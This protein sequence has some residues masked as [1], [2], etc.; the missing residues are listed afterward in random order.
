[1]TAY[2]YFVKNATKLARIAKGDLTR[3]HA[4]PATQL[5]TETYKVR[6]VDAKKNITIV[7]LQ[8]ITQFVNPVTIL[9]ITV[10]LPGLQHA[11]RAT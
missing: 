3:I 10:L 11:P 4:L 1:M 5:T 6:N 2:I 9:V 7:F 8:L